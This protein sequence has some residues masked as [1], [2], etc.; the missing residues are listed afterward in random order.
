MENVLRRSRSVLNFVPQFKEVVV[1]D[2]RVSRH[3]RSKT[4]RRVKPSLTDGTNGRQS[5]Q[6]VRGLVRLRVNINM[7]VEMKTLISKFSCQPPCFMDQK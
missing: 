4:V 5:W 1:C 6:N 2:K 7:K 3:N